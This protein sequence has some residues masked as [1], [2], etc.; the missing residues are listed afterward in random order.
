MTE[1]TEKSQPRNVLPEDPGVGL[2][3]TLTAVRKHWALIVACATLAA[4]ASLRHY[5]SFAHCPSLPNLKA[6]FAEKHPEF[7]R[8]GIH[9]MAS[10][11]PAGELAIGDS[12]VY[13][14]DIDPFN[15][16]EIDRAI[17][18][19]FDS[20]LRPPD[21][22]I[23]QKWA[24]FYAKSEI[25]PSE[26]IRAPSG[27]VRLILPPGGTGMTHAFGLAARTFD[28]WDQA[29]SLQLPLR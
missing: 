13:G 22:R 6:R 27:N 11:N 25:P 7:D 1:E 26:L 20:F 21:R 23:L 24:G 5:S 18:E 10:Q 9:V 29:H 2:L 4:G 15:S 19:Y 8:F 3:W 14:D 16:E 28:T 12:H 17:L